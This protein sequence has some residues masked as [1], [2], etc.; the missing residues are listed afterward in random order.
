MVISNLV[1]KIL[2]F[3]WKNVDAF[4]VPQLKFVKFNFTLFRVVLSI[5]DSQYFIFQC[6]TLD[7]IENSC[8]QVQWSNTSPGFLE[9]FC[10]FTIVI[11]KESSYG[12]VFSENF[13]TS[14][15]VW[16]STTIKSWMVVRSIGYSEI[17]ILCWFLL[18]KIP[19]SGNFQH[20]TLDFAKCS[21]KCICCDSKYLVKKLGMWTKTREK[22]AKKYRKLNF[23]SSH[24]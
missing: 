23:R 10:W 15:N 6:W 18:S 24:D 1:Q 14:P 16:F 17:V 19:S 9:Q 5:T 13:N 20:K 21:L 12:R 7:L 22:N 11:H 8:L 4:V 2:E 3:P